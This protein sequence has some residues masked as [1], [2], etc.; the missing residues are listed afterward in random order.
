MVNLNS[1][2]TKCQR[3][4]ESLSPIPFK[5]TIHCK[6]K[7]HTISPRRIAD[8]SHTKRPRVQQVTKI[9]KAASKRV[10]ELKNEETLLDNEIAACLYS[11][12]D[13]RKQKKRKIGRDLQ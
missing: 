12:G 2:T 13:T 1:S 6:H 11:E 8:I 9:A 4:N 3:R 7:L 10:L 5:P